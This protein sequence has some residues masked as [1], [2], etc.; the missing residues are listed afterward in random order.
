MIATRRAPASNGAQNYAY[1]ADAVFQFYQNIQ[2][3]EYIA[4][5]ETPGRTGNDLSYRT[6][7]IWNADRWG[8][9]IERM[10]AGEDFNPEIGCLRRPEGFHRNHSSFRFSPRPKNLRGVRKMFVQGNL[11]YF[12]N[13]ADTSVESR[14]QQGLV[15]ADFTSGDRTTVDVH[16]QLRGHQSA[17][18][19]GQGRPRADRR[20]CIPAGDGQLHVRPATESERHGQRDARRLLRRHS[21]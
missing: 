17:L 16:A 14:E 11:E 13:A 18:H 19:S 10:F 4:K 12:T 21:H 7:F 3:I 2:F 15:R 6:R 20:L 5:T 9:D 1:G 8:I